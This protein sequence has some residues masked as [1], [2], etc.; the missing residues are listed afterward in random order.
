MSVKLLTGS[1]RRHV[2]FVVFSSTKTPP[3]RDGAF[4]SFSTTTL[5]FENPTAKYSFPLTFFS[6]QRE[7]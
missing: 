5:R 1:D 7:A 6:A 2:N 3:N 4:T